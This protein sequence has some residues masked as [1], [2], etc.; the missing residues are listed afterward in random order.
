MALSVYNSISSE[1]YLGVS[2][3]TNA[4]PDPSN[5]DVTSDIGQHDQQFEEVDVP[6]VKYLLY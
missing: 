1:L 2:L 5:G 3:G 4:T 6:K